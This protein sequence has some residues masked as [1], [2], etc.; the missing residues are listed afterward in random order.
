[1][2]QFR[3]RYKINCSHF[4][5]GIPLRTDTVLNGF[6]FSDN[7][8]GLSAPSGGRIAALALTK[9]RNTFHGDASSEHLDQASKKAPASPR[10][11]PLIGAKVAFL[12]S[13]GISQVDIATRLS[14]TPSAVSRLLSPG[15][16]AHKFLIWERPK[17]Q[18]DLVSDDADAVRALQGENELS[19]ELTQRLIAISNVRLKVSVILTHAEDNSKLHEQ[20]FYAR[21]AELV[22][23]L[24]GRDRTNI[25][26]VTWGKSL[27]LLLAEAQKLR[28]ARPLNSESAEVIPLVGE[29]LGAAFPTSRSSSALAQRFAAAL[30]NQD[31]VQGRDGGTG[32]K[33]K[34]HS[35]TMCPVFLPVSFKKQ[36]VAVVKE[37]LAFVP[38]YREIFGD[39]D[40]DL[41]RHGLIRPPLAERV[42]VILTSISKH[43]LPFGMGDDSSFVKKIGL[44]ILNDVLVGD[45]GGLPLF[46]PS[47]EPAKRRK[48][49]DFYE[50]HW[51]GLKQKHVYETARRARANIDGPAGV[52]VVASGAE[53]AIPIHE[54]VKNELINELIIDHDAANSLRMLIH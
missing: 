53:R 12:R 32:K 28:L 40:G 23:R 14:L 30:I 42:D 16:D 52:I 49:N 13:E 24:L 5:H 48:A 43:G 9:N 6:I 41:G 2:K 18:W 34:I 45:I 21:S 31:E 38:S 3:A 20:K 22:W 7:Q 47:A 29:S 36:E 50:T 25:V 33:I 46:R 26:G 54:A 11:D 37:L 17:F 27:D 15:G 35:L 51:L 10:E 1:V 8:V 19:I 44:H 4:H 39:D